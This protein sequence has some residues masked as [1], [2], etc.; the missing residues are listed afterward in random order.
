MRYNVPSENLAHDNNSRAGGRNDSQFFKPLRAAR[1]QPLSPTL[2]S[3][4]R[5]VDLP[6]PA[7]QV[8]ALAR[9]LQLAD[10]GGVTNLRQRNV[11]TRRI[12]TRGAKNLPNDF[13]GVTYCRKYSWVADV[14]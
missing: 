13:A 4:A 5:D 9:K 7:D 6:H 14:A 8:P 1:S 12:T 11:L 10:H 3:L 2:T